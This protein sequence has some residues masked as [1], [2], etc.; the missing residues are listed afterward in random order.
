MNL[1]FKSEF[2][3][4]FR[5]NKS[6]IPSE[7]YLGILE[8]PGLERGQMCYNSAKSQVSFYE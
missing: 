8:F 4:S 3:L 7:I 6:R 2:L 1:F 5:L